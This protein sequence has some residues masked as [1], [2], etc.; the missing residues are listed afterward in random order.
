M[1]QEGQFH[2]TL[3]VD[4]LDLIDRF[5]KSRDD[6]IHIKLEFLAREF[7]LKLSAVIEEYKKS[8][9][10]LTEA[11]LEV[12]EADAKRDLAI[13]KHF[14][15][16]NNLLSRIDRY[17][18]T[19]LTDD[20]VTKKIE[21]ALANQ[22][23]LVSERLGLAYAT[24]DIV[25]QKINASL[26]AYEKSHITV[27]G[28]D[29]R[30]LVSISNYSKTCSD[31]QALKDQAEHDRYK[32]LADRINIVS[33]ITVFVLGVVGTVVLTHFFHIV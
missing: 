19:Y 24:K 32:N 12:K 13:E 26:I 2:Q 8:E 31:T 28:V 21:L 7:E 9:R 25:D 23:R 15:S 22:E 16:S 27:E 10:L 18:A 33:G 20:M 14:E 1:E 6:K 30:I 3:Y 17:T 4:T 29:N 11:R 5:D